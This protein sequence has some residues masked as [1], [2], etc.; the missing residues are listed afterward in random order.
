MNLDNELKAKLCLLPA[1]F[2]ALAGCMF[3]LY[4]MKLYNLN[5]ML[6]LFIGISL[7]G[8]LMIPS[9]FEHAKFEQKYFG[10]NRVN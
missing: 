2:M 4:L 1:P 8:V 7:G 6:S 10:D 5:G 9:F 3:G